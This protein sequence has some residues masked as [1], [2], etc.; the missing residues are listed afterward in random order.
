MGFYKEKVIEQMDIRNCDGNCIQ[1]SFIVECEQAIKKSIEEDAYNNFI[2][3][4]GGHC[5]HG[6]CNN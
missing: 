6:N 1:C 2:S 4:L 3:S 5:A